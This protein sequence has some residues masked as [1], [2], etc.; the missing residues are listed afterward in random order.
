MPE[1][2]IDCDEVFCPAASPPW[3]ERAWAWFTGLFD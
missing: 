2:Q 3:Y 1:L